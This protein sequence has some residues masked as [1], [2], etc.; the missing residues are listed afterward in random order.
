MTSPVLSI[1]VA[2]SKNGVIGKD[3]DLPWRLSTDLKHF[4]KTTMGKPVLM[5]RV[6]WE[7]LPFPLPGR[8]NL[9]LS[10]N[11]NYQA[12]GAEVFDN[13]HAMIGRGFEL[14][15]LIGEQEIMII[16]G[17]NLYAQTIKYVDKLYISE[18]DCMIE[19]DAHFPALQ[20]SDF[21]LVS[22]HSYVKGPK[23]DFN[24]VV[25][26]YERRNKQL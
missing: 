9:V 20:I 18:V 14:A 13:L 24:F 4:K 8:P 6:S 15:G 5:G 17:A 26:T 21:N 7:S 2:K 25:K 16:G 22:E 12:K 11:K 3:G 10:R 23:D 19:G 1:I